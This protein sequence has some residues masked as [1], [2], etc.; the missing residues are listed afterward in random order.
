MYTLDNNSQSIIAVCF[1]LFEL[2]IL[3]LLHNASKLTPEPGNLFLAIS[4]VSIIFSFEIFS[5]FINESSLLRCPI[6][7][8]AL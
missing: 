6:S 3:Y 5:L 4:R 1:S 7:N 8:S 2:S